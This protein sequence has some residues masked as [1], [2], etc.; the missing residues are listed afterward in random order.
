MW[1]L[2][3]LRGLHLPPSLR[4]FPQA[5]APRLVILGHHKALM[6]EPPVHDSEDRKELL[7]MKEQV[8][9]FVDRTEFPIRLDM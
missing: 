2:Y 1:R 5:L 8:R 9:P 3:G 4:A 6:P 7:D